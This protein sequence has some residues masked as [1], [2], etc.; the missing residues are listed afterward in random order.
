M[1]FYDLHIPTRVFLEKECRS[2][3]SSEGFRLHEEKDTYSESKN[4]S[5]IINIVN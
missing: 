5:F 2:C 3:A 1:S 4:V